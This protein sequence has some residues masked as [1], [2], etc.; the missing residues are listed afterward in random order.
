M[1]LIAE[2][3]NNAGAPAASAPAAVLVNDM[4]LRRMERATDRGAQWL[5]SQHTY[6]PYGRDAS[7]QSAQDSPASARSGIS[8]ISERDMLHTVNT[9]GQMAMRANEDTFMSMPT[10]SASRPYTY[11]EYPTAWIFKK[12][13]ITEEEARGYMI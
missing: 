7:A 6:M 10:T 9:G 2:A 4:R 11:D 3:A 8:A 5:Q 13:P 12:N 1:P